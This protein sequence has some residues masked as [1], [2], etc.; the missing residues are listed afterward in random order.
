MKGNVVG[1]A[2]ASRETGKL[3]KAPNLSR[4]GN[5]PTHLVHSEPYE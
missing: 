5:M 2:N 4:L 1:L 3:G